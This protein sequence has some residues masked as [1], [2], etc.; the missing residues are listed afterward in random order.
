MSE[1]E[2]IGE[3]TESHEDLR[4]GTQNTFLA[5][6]LLLMGFSIIP[7]QPFTRA[8]GKGNKAAVTVWFFPYIT[9]DNEG[10]QLERPLGARR[11]AQAFATNSKEMPFLFWMRRAMEARQWLV[12][13]VI[14]EARHPM[15]GV[16]PAN[17][18]KTDDLWNA[19]VAV[20][21]GVKFLGYRD[22]EF[23]FHAQAQLTW[24]KARL[25]DGAHRERWAL[26]ALKQQRDLM[27]LIRA[28]EAE[29]TI[30]RV[31]GPT[32]ATAFIPQ[33]MPDDLKRAY[34]HQLFN[35]R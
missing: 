6:C 22:K 9:H 17:S 29:A 1:I 12:K 28:R 16:P 19:A 8:V 34:L 4:Y 25:L 21:C 15:S 7:T 18:C 2:V 5:T 35:P 32:H 31:A 10:K 14:H 30:A 3:R 23:Y 27:D 20:S 11:V 33:L 13:E 26:L 24:G